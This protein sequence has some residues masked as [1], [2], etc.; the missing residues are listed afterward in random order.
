MKCL[1]TLSTTHANGRH[2]RLSSAASIDE[3]KKQ[4]VIAIE[5]DGAGLPADAMEVV[6]RIGQRLDEQVSGSGLGLPIVRDL[7]Q[8]YGGE[9]LLENAVKGGLRATLKLPRALT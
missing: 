4:V 2:R 5:D 3:N 7:A 9:V 1:P 6:F 8:L